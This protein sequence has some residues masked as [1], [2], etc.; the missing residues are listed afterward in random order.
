MRI[1]VEMLRARGACQKQV[2]LFAETFPGGA[3]PATDLRSAI[4]AG[5]E[6]LWAECLLQG[7][8]LAQYQEIQ[9]Q[10]WA[11]Y[12]AIQGQ[13]RAQYNEIQGQARAQYEAIRNQAWAQYEAILDQAWA[14]YQAIQ[15]QALAS[16][17][18]AMTDPSDCGGAA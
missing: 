2:A 10:A 14:Q 12:Q 8:A 5:L 7:S 16:S 18:S 15:G 9:D 6:I 13:A 3:D 17:L 11:Q 4:D 1:T